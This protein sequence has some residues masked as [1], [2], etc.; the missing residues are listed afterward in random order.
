[1]PMLRNAGS[2]L[3]RSG[4]ALVQLAV[5]TAAL[6]AIWVPVALVVGALNI[7]SVAIRGESLGDMELLIE[8]LVWWMHQVK[9]LFAMSDDFWAIPYAGM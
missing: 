3:L 2:V 7:L 8:P 5:A 9:V 6:I 4:L 1:M